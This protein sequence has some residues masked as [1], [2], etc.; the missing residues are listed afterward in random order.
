[1]FFYKGIT[2]E[3]KPVNGG[4]FVKETGNAHENYSFLPGKDGY[5]NGFVETKHK[6]GFKAKDPKPNQLHIEKIDPMAKDADYIDNVTV[7]FCAKPST[8]KG[9]IELVGWYEDATIYRDRKY[10]IADDGEKMGTNIRTDNGK[11]F[12]IPEGNRKF[13]IPRASDGKGVGFGQSNIWYAD[14]P[15]GEAF[16]KKALSMTAWECLLG[17]NFF[18][19]GQTGR[20]RLFR[21]KRLWGALQQIDLLFFDV[22]EEMKHCRR[23]IRRYLLRYET[24]L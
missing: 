18:D 9:D 6:G 16:K 12:L 1:M 3:D 24:I 5:V 14:G 2:E 11:A 8:G 19:S 22:T 17:T 7:F 15:E 13:I 20:L 10:Y 23:T 4:L 21:M